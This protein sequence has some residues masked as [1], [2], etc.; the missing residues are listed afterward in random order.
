MLGS[1]LEL[2][3][4]ASGNPVPEYSWVHH[5]QTDSAVR[6]HEKNLIIAGV[7][8]RDQGQYECRA[9]NI[10]HGEEITVKSSLVTVNVTGAPRVAGP[11]SEVFI[12][13]V[14]EFCSL[15]MTNETNCRKGIS[16]PL[17]FLSLLMLM[18][19]WCRVRTRW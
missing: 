14:Q 1:K 15:F 12:L 9:T 5:T 7:E 8:Y 6:G 13:K 16:V 10:V 2:V 17:G 19:C 3:C 11:M 4:E 18:F